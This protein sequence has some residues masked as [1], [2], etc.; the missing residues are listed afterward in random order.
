MK[1]G[2]I[3]LTQRNGIYQIEVSGLV[4]GFPK[5]ILQTENPQDLIDLKSCIEEVLFEEHD[6][7]LS[8]ALGEESE[9]KEERPAFYTQECTQIC[10]G[11]IRE[12]GYCTVHESIAPQTSKECECSCHGIKDECVVFSCQHCHQPSKEVKFRT[13][14]PSELGAFEVEPSKEIKCEQCEVNCGYS[15]EDDECSH[16]CHGLAGLMPRPSKEKEECTAP[17]ELCNVFLKECYHCGSGDCIGHEC[18]EK[19]EPVENKPVQKEE[20]KEEKKLCWCGHP[21]ENHEKENFTFEDGGFFSP[22]CIYKDTI[23]GEGKCINC[24]C[25]EFKEKE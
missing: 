11:T 6:R 20:T 9:P 18:L 2:N 10:E 5:G 8:E 15:E 23:T 21:K 13:K 17:K 22:I 1:R 7:K 3:E 24:A 19:K 14:H 25:R 16:Y 4:V 12:Y